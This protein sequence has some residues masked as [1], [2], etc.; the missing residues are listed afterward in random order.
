AE[1]RL[2]QALEQAPAED[3]WHAQLELGN[4]A[5]DRGQ[6][7][8]AELRYR[9]VLRTLP[10]QPEAL[11][12]L[13]GLLAGSARFEE[14]ATLND[15]LLRVAPQVALRQGLLHAELLRAA[16][17]KSRAARSVDQARTQ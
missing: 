8:E 4:F 9:E 7:G 2:L 11:R 15:R 3:K 12:G 1:S 13:V 5:L 6:G 17:A 14:A 10:E 16:A